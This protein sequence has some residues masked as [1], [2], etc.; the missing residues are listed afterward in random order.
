[1]KCIDVIIRKE[2][3]EM[4][5]IESLK[6]RAEGDKLLHDTV[7]QI[8]TISA[9]AIAIAIPYVEKT[10][11][12]KALAAVALLSFLISIIASGICMRTISLKMGLAYGTYDMA[13]K[14]RQQRIEDRVFPFA[15]PSFLL[16][17]VAL[18]MYVIKNMLG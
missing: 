11:Q 9:G 15:I 4:P 12:W 1:M 7:K 17:V 6:L 3:G 5:G 8:A 16:A 13:E 18:V 10:K 14:K 2:S